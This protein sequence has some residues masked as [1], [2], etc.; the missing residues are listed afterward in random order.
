[1]PATPMAWAYGESIPDI[2]VGPG[3][4]MSR[5]G[6]YL[7]G[8]WDTPD[9]TGQRYFR[10]IETYQEEWWLEGAREGD[11]TNWDKLGPATLYAR[12]ETTAP[13][14]ARVWD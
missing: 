10:F 8:F 6:F 4:L 14:W 9:A 1:M 2:F 7:W 11:P 3:G 5:P 13:P 12:W